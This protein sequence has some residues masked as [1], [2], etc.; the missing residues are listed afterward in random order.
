MFVDNSY[1]QLALIKAEKQKEKL[2]LRKYA[3][4]SIQSRFPANSMIQDFNKS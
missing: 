2:L 1:I 4:A 3:L